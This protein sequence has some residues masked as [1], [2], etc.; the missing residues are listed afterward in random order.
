MDENCSTSTATGGENTNTTPDQGVVLPF[1]TNDLP[2][3]LRK[4]AC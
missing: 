3:M 1:N 2:W 4:Q